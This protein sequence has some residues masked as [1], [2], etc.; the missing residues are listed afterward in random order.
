MYLYSYNSFS[1][2]VSV[3]YKIFLFNITFF[4]IQSFYPDFFFSCSI[5]KV[6]ITCF[7]IQIWKISI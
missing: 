4:F 3:C 5:N 6:T 1:L 2:L 7:I